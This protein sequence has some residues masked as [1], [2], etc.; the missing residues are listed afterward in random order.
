VQKLR[1]L[2]EQQLRKELY[3][4]ADEVD[5]VRQRFDAVDNRDVGQQLDRAPREAVVDVEDR[6]GHAPL[7]QRPDE[8][9]CADPQA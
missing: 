5:G 7:A 6:D 9:A 4:D 1:V 3:G 8:V 2:L